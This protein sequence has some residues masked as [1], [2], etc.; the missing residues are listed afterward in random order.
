MPAAVA[1][2]IC[3]DLA[4]AVT[5]DWDMSNDRSA[6]LQVPNLADTGQ[7]IH[8]WHLRVHQDQGQMLAFLRL[9]LPKLRFLQESDG[10]TAMVG[11]R[12]HVHKYA[13]RCVVDSCLIGLLMHHQKGIPECLRHWNA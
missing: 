10:F 6:R 9:I 4:F 3:S 8:Y 11:H 13:V 5:D 2:S 12:H 1:T 7:T